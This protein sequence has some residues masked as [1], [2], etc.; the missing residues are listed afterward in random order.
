MLAHRKN[1][2]E[3]RLAKRKNLVYTP[4]YAGVKRRKTNSGGKK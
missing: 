3:K 4:A 1:I 2:F